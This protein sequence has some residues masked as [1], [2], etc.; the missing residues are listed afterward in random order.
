MLW[1]TVLSLKAVVIEEIP[2]DLNDNEPR[3]K[4]LLEE[5]SLGQHC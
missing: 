2:E 5:A 3:A 4:G 1:A